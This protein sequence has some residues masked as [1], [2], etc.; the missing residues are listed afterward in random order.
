MERELIKRE[1]DGKG[2]KRQTGSEKSER[3]TEGSR[4]RGKERAMF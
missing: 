2:E 3:R 4:R 1:R